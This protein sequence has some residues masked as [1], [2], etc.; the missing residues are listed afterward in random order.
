[1]ISSKNRYS[2]AMRE[3]VKKAMMRKKMYISQLLKWVCWRRR[4][5]R[6]RSHGLEYSD[7]VPTQPLCCGHV[8]D[9]SRILLYRRYQERFPGSER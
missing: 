2:I 7:Q 6:D 1:M 3:G 9:V 5:I 4:E 8:F